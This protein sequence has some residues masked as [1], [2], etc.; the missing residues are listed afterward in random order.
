MKRE[1][2]MALGCQSKRISVIRQAIMTAGGRVIDIG[3]SNGEVFEGC[4]GMADILGIDVL[5]PKRPL[6]SAY[7]LGFKKINAEKLPFAD[8]EFHL[9]VLAE[10]LEHVPNPAKILKEAQ[11]VA[12]R[13]LISTPNEYAWSPQ[14]Q[15]FENDAHIRH[16]RTDTIKKEIEDAGLSILY[17]DLINFGGWSFFMAIAS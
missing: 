11:R 3:C 9:A 8:K 14:L 6:P 5:K 13:V 17:F 4:D 1:W 16:Y 7:N 10:I 2:M 15:P 12:N